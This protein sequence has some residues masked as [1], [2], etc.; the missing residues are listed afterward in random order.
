[1]ATTRPFSQH[2]VSLSNRRSAEQAEEHA[3]QVAQALAEAE[4]A[5]RAER[6]ES[7]GT[8]TQAT[9]SEGRLLQTISR[10]HIPFPPLDPCAVKR[11][12]RQQE[13]DQVDVKAKEDASFRRH[14]F[15]EYKVRPLSHYFL[16]R[17]VNI[18]ST[19]L[20]TPTSAI[21]EL[22]ASTGSRAAGHSCKRMSDKTG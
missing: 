1:M 5:K 11:E 20:T 19:L 9:R 4:Q 21:T 17:L 8:G 13:L 22:T 14:A 3:K 2:P 16:C 15:N 18:E 12:Q 7:R 6:D 10:T